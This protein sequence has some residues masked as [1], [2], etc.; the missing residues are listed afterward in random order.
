MSYDSQENRILSLEIS[1]KDIMLATENFSVNCFGSGRYWKAYEGKLPNASTTIV[2]KRWDSK[3]DDQFGT[4]LD[5]LFKRK[6]KNII[7]LVGYCSERNE[8]I[9][10]YEH[11]SKGSLDKYLKDSK[12]KWMKRLQICIDVA[13]ALDFLHG[14]NVTLKKVVHRN[15]KSHSILLNDDW[16]AK[17]SNFELSSL[18]SSHQNIKYI[19]KDAYL[20]PQYN[21]G[22]LTE[23]SDIYS[24]GV[25]L[26]EILC[27]RL[28]WEEGHEAGPL[29]KHYY[30]QAKLDEMVF[31]DIK[32]QIVPQS[33]TTF[34]DIAYEC[35][36]ED[37]DKRPKAGDVVIQLKKALEIQEDF[38]LWEPKLPRDYKEIMGLSQTPEIYHTK[39]KK[40]LYEKLSGGILL[41]KE[42]VWFILSDNG[43]SNKMISATAAKFTYKNHQQSHKF[44]S[45]HISRFQKVA[46]ILDISNL[47]I[48][49]SADNRLLSPDV[50]YGI[51]LVFKISD[52]RIF[53]RNCM[54]M[55]LKY[56]NGPETLHSYFA[57]WRD[58]DW[59]MIEL[60]RFLNHKEDV[61]FTFL[62]ESF[63]RYYCTSG[64][65]F[66]EGIEFQAIKNASLKY[67]PWFSF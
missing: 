4:E 8:N 45:I 60:H 54:F 14:E 23:K 18:D 34:V 57:T 22:S 52:P 59:M 6:H 28:T 39:Q 40:D 17:I 42:K 58:N 13:S 48:Q 55:N 49:V 62:L 20:D 9:I 27:G 37:A 65:I 44:R 7:R 10:V 3:S 5:I 35:L 1:L 66:I 11:M 15:I 38:E 24:F 29:A 26:F 16:D 61:S 43:E 21:Q 51:Y 32:E 33:L 36:H 41:P 56:K 30:E 53:S 46:K 2:A 12:L 64:A 63:S 31:A 47:K 25:I 19:N 50:T 67:T